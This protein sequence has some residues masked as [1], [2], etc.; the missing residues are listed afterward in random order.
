MLIRYCADNLAQSRDA[1]WKKSRPTVDPA[2]A[3]LKP[4]WPRGLPV[5]CLTG[6]VNVAWNLA[7][8]QTPFIADRAANIVMADPAVVFV[9]IPNDKE[10]RHAIGQ[11]IDSFHIA[12]AIYVML[13][14]S[15]NERQ[16]RIHAAWSHAINALSQRL[17]K[18]EA[19]KFWR[20]IFERAIP[21][22]Q[23]PGSGIQVIQ[24][25]PVIPEDDDPQEPLEWNPAA[26]IPPDIESRELPATALDC[27][28]AAPHM[29]NWDTRHDFHV[30]SPK[31]QETL[32]T[33]IWSYHGLTTFG[34]IHK[35]VQ[36]GMI[37]TALLIE[38]SK[39]EGS[40]LMT[41]PFPS[42]VNVR[43]PSL[44]LD[45]D[46]L[47]SRHAS[48]NPPADIALSY[49]I[50]MVPSTQLLDLAGSALDAL[51]K[52]PSD[53][54]KLV[55]TERTA[56]SQ[57]KLLS[58]SDRPHLASN[59]I[60]RTVI[61]RPDASSWQRQ[62]LTKSV[63]RSLSSEKA[64]DMISLFASS[65]L[66]ALKNQ[67]TTPG[68]QQ[69]AVGSNLS[70]GRY[71]KVTTVKFLAQ[72]LDDA[73]FVSPEFCVDTLSKVFQKASH[74]D[75]RAAVLDSMLSRLG[76][77]RDESSD[78]V[79]ERL[80]SALEMMIPIVGSLN[81]RRQIQD[82]DWAE[83]EKSGK[84]PE[85]YDDG[86]MQAFPPMLSAIL[87]TDTGCDIPEDIL[88][89]GYTRRI[90]L[91]L[92]KE[93]KEQC[94]RWVKMFTLKQLPV[95]QSINLPPVPIR[96]GILMYLIS[97]YSK[98]LPRY[99][100]DLHQ[101][102]FLINISP[103]AG[104]IKL[105]SKINNDVRL[106]DSNEGQ[107]WKSLYGQGAQIPTVGIVSMLTKPWKSSLVSDGI[108]LSHVQEAVFEQAEA[109]YDIADESFH[110]WNNFMAPLEPPLAAYYQT[111]EEREAWVANG[112]PIVLRIIKRIDDL[113]T[114]A[115]QQDPNRKPA[116]LPPTFGL[117]LWLLD[118]PQLCKS[119]GSCATFAQQ[120]VSVLQEILDLGLAHYAKLKDVETALSR[121]LTHDGIRVACFLGS[122]EQEDSMNS[123]MKM[124][125]VQLADA[126]LRRVKLPQD[127]DD[128]T[129]Q[130]IEPMLNAWRNSELED[131]RMRGI[132]LGKLW[133]KSS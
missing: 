5:Q 93:S 37:A 50:N 129:V 21:H 36:E 82:E 12:L 99:I 94:A 97:R 85:V 70:S 71:I 115:W 2:V 120:I 106:R 119:P 122:V 79:A 84:L 108:R 16:S 29:L 66:E 64:Q 98:H 40:K 68:N 14:P 56:F 95:G 89:R 42:D 88:R 92:L 107:F 3:A 118:Y 81:D 87:R 9:N 1:L 74:V 101:Q 124:L 43:Y 28:I 102:F 127:K 26:K 100:L 59:L 125:R 117:R 58:K 131:I 91:P 53:S 7:F 51:S 75:I 22:A 112:K 104:L 121:C 114:P 8:T 77:C 33:P 45:H 103:P 62:L 132:R 11:F 60:V 67:G 18:S 76:R 19:E 111:N 34:R 126:Q 83:A 54:T 86:G 128:E 109:L 39:I 46:F 130:S 116:V 30:P 25:Y 47:L 80:M 44:F 10:T 4:P 52:M 49:F 17:S 110:H 35:L 61:D 63:I 90:V 24:E 38:S 48:L 20:N 65:I 55:S 31:T 96:P 113:R 23:I 32:S 13:A 123:Q 6:R 41:S 69:K 78:A 27:N 57:L 133:R 72:L 105:N 73:D 15:D